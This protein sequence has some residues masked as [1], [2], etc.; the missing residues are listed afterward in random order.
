MTPKARVL[1][2]AF[3]VTGLGIAQASAA[4]D[5]GGLSTPTFSGGVVTS[6]NYNFNKEGTGGTAPN[7]MATNLLHAYDNRANTFSLDEATLIV[8]GHSADKNFG[9]YV[10]FD[11]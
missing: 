2:A 8:E 6:Y 4:A 1:S 5:A 7:P 9:Y 11:A 3:I 10:Q